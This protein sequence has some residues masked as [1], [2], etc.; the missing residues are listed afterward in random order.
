MNPR[1]FIARTIG[2]TTCA[3]S[4]LAAQSSEP[5]ALA[6]PERDTLQCR[7]VPVPKTAHDDSTGL[8]LHFQVGSDFPNAR[9]IDVA[10]DTTGRATS[11]REHLDTYRPSQGIQI[12]LLTII[13]YPDGRT[14]GFTI[15][16][17][18]NATKSDS[19]ASTI[20]SLNR[21][22]TQLSDQQKTQARRL[23]SWLWE[24]RCKQLRS[25]TAATT[26]PSHKK[27]S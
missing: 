8:A 9:T 11:L 3:A 17:R 25:R 14:A 18:R 7:Y 21:T 15:S 4:M 1:S 2:L 5:R 20:A 13:F 27:P 24:H 16:A 26:A 23:A 19:G 12:D 10:Y 22:V 6:I